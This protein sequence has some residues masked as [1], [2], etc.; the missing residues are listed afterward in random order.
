[1]KAINLL[2]EEDDYAFA[3]ASSYAGINAS[4]NK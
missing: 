3:Y 4:G 2:L 1:M